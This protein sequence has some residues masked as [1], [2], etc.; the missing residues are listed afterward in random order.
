MRLAAVV[1]EELERKVQCTGVRERTAPMTNCYLTKKK[2]AHEANICSLARCCALYA[3][4]DVTARFILQAKLFLLSQRSW[5]KAAGRMPAR[6][7]C[8]PG[9][10]NNIVNWLPGG[11]PLEEVS[12]NLLKSRHLN[13]ETWFLHV[14]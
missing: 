3:P 9:R 10:H 11:K 5:R 8:N 1:V 2:K 14:N 13:L 12:H 4:G 7:T 6:R